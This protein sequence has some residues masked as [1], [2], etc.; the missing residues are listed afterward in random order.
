MATPRDD[1]SFR[2]ANLESPEYRDRL[3]RKLNC[4]IAVLE[5]ACAKVRRTLSG[6]DPDVDRLLRIHKNLRETLEVCLRARRALERREELPDGLP[7][8]LANAMEIEIPRGDFSSPAE[9]QRFAGRA[10]IDPMEVA[11]ADWDELTR[12]LQK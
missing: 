10:P 8:N 7:E 5:V 11:G 9:E 1:D 2:D 4:L 3:M 6:P 12:L